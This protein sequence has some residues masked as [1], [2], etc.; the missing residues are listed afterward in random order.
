MSTDLRMQALIARIMAMPAAQ[1][2]S[3]L[4]PVVAPAT[5]TAAA[6]TGPV[7][8]PQ[9]MLLPATPPT[10]TAPQL[11]SPPG[12][13]SFAALPMTDVPQ[14]VG[15]A[16]VPP[17]PTNPFLKGSLKHIAFSLPEVTPAELFP[18]YEFHGGTFSATAAKE[19]FGNL[20][21]VQTCQTFAVIRASDSR[22]KIVH[23]LGR[24][25]APF[26]SE[27]GDVHH[28]GYFAFKGDTTARRSPQIIH[29]DPTMLQEYKVRVRPEQ[30]IDEHY[31]REGA[32]NII[33]IN[34]SEGDRDIT[35]M[36]M[37]P[38]KWA[39]ALVDKNASPHEF[40]S[41]IVGKTKDW[42]TD[43]GKYRE[44]L[45][46]WAMAACTAANKTGGKNTSQLSS[47]LLDVDP[48]SD[49]LEAWAEARLNLILGPR[50]TAPSP[51][52]NNG[53]GGGSGL[54]PVIHVNMPP[55]PQPTLDELELAFH[56]GADSQKRRTE[57]V[58]PSGSKYTDSQFI[59]LLAFCGLDSATR[60]ELPKI[61][62]TL[63]GARAWHDAAS[64]LNKW[65]RVHEGDDNE[66]SPYQFHK[67]L[68]ED[69][70]KLMF[71]L[72]PA[73]LADNAHRGI[74]PLAFGLMTVAEENALRED[75]EARDGATALTPAAVR[76]AKRKCPS[77]PQL[78]Q[79]LIVLLR[80]YIK[81]G[82]ILFTRKCHH[83][84]EVVRI[85]AEL[86]LMQRR[87]GNFLDVARIA[88]LVWDI[89][90][91]SGQ[92]FNTFPTEEEFSHNPQRGMPT[93]NLG[94]VRSLLSSNKHI[95]SIDT[96]ARW[97]PRPTYQPR[98]QNVLGTPRQHLRREGGGGGGGVNGGYGGN[99]G[100]GRT[101]RQTGGG[102]RLTWG[103]PP[104]DTEG[105]NT[106]EGGLLHRNMDMHA[107]LASVMAPLYEKNIDWRLGSLCRAAGVED[108]RLLPRLH[109]YCFRWMLGMC[110]HKPGDPARC[111]YRPEH[112]HPRS[113]K[114][115]DDY[116]VKL[117]Q[118]LQPG[119]TKIL[120]E[121]PTAGKR[122]RA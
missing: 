118:L 93:S 33:P 26:G 65:F 19:K 84:Q 119:V 108:M 73:P 104:G 55:T 40:L 77:I 18:Y 56:K 115:P 114:V 11:V 100:N 105:G 36:V 10:T 58:V 107:T 12:R 25:M 96:P 47:P 75:Q 88:S 85:K 66:D 111:K 43:D 91:D 120:S 35:K 51:T 90:V 61:W 34:D 95:A 106:R 109:N 14:P 87:N 97:L 27:T 72:G 5:P 41:F 45:V 20:A 101:Q 2:D 59:H 8:A 7:G 38:V 54:A 112:L 28:E 86:T 67:E 99:G 37:L 24:Y 1:R 94:V 113:N 69:L 30:E 83:F 82:H 74:S 70:R 78:L 17:P 71:S 81:A 52:I 3:L 46:N 79:D 92:F 16:P 22:I 23:S 9:L 49:A 122:Q 4:P 21:N 117:G 48:S 42:D 121:T 32:T 116:A 76:A 53:F 57:T 63:Q 13:V 89:I 29:V 15:A 110:E 80:R 60:H 62:T 39:G 50:V 103:S 68:V 98:D 102:T 31:A 44:Y 6:I 64:E